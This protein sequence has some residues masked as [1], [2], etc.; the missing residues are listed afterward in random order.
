MPKSDQGVFHDRY[1]VI[2]RTL[3]FVTRGDEVL[4]IKGS[5]TKRL[6]AN[7]FNGIG[8]HIE[9]GEDVLNAARRELMEEAGIE[10]EN[11]RLCGTLIVDA[12]ESVGIGIFI[13]K[14]EY[15]Q[16]TVRSSGEGSPQWVRQADLGELP[17]VEDLAVI[18]PEVLAQQ[19]NQA[20]FSARSF[21][22]VQ[23]HLQVEIT[24]NLE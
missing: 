11:L 22:D 7:R 20:P 8:G 19:A 16:G 18:L 1:Q 9:R 4:L 15:R 5:P 23:E 3:I 2:P 6:W 21:Y 14:G 17:L 24:R 12:S 10:V 13:L